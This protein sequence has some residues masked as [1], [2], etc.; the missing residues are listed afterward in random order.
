ME[1][2]ESYRPLLFSIAYRMMGSAMEAEDIVQDAYLRVQTAADEAIRNPKGYLTTITTHLC[3]DRIKSAQAQREQYTGMWLPEPIFTD[4]IDQPPADADTLSMAFLVLLQTLN[5]VER[6]VFV[7]REVFEYSYEDIATIVD[8]EAAACRQI[9]HRA[10]ERVEAGKP[11]YQHPGEAGRA[12]AERFIQA[13]NDGDIASVLNMLAPDV[14]SSSDG[15]G[16]VAASHRPI[17][18]R[19][20]VMRL[21]LGLAKRAPEGVSWYYREVN[22]GPGL[23]I[24]VHGEIFAVIALDTSDEGIEAFY[25]MVNPDKLERLRRGGG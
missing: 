12:L 13:C 17:R 14:M 8:K 19:D 10:Q 3:L 22:Y 4:A 5:P 21:L 1:A 11:R 9:F 6:A 18:G 23:V 16:K 7:L 25:Y 20:A 15:G 2:F 24:A